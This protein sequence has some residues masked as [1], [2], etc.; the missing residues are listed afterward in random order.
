VM[1]PTYLNV[2]FDYLSPDP[3]ITPH[4]IYARLQERGKMLVNF[5][6]LPDHGIPPF[7]RVIFNNTNVC[8]KL[9]PVILDEIH[10]AAQE[11]LSAA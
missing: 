3:D 9:C 7:F 2:C 4:Q 6:P 8:K 10:A 5:N 11:L 1:K